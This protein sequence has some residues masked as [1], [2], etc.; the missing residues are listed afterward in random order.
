MDERELSRRERR[1]NSNE[2]VER[3]QVIKEGEEG[4]VRGLIF[5]L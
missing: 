2:K 5:D 1:G 3:K 4:D